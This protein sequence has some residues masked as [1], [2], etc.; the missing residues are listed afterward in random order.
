MNL[1]KLLLIVLAL[2][3]SNQVEFYDIHSNYEVKPNDSIKLELALK[4]VN[5]TPLYITVKFWTKD[6]T[7]KLLS[8]EF[9]NEMILSQATIYQELTASQL[10][11]NTFEFNIKNPTDKMQVF[12]GFGAI[13]D[14]PMPKLNIDFAF[15]F[16]KSEKGTSIN[17]NEFYTGS[18][19]DNLRYMAYYS[20]EK[21]DPLTPYEVLLD[22]DI[23]T[24]ETFEFQVG[25]YIPNRIYTNFFIALI[26]SQT[27][28][29]KMYVNFKPFS[30]CDILD[31]TKVLSSSIPTETLYCF[32]HSEKGESYLTAWS[33][34]E[35]YKLDIS[36]YYEIDGM[37]NSENLKYSL[38]NAK[39]IKLEVPSFKKTAYSVIMI[40]ATSSILNN[41]SYFHL[42]LIPKL[43]HFVAL[44][45][46]DEI[47]YHSSPF[48]KSVMLEINRDQTESINNVKIQVFSETDIIESVELFQGESQNQFT[49]LSLAK[50]INGAYILIQSLQPNNTASKL[51]ATIKL[52]ASASINLENLVRATLT[53]NEIIELEN[54]KELA[55]YDTQNFLRLSYLLEIGEQTSFVLNENFDYSTIKVFISDKQNNFRI[56]DFTGEEVK[57]NEGIVHFSSN[58]YP[59]A[60]SVLIEGLLAYPRKGYSLNISVVETFDD[61]FNYVLNVGSTSNDPAV[62][63]LKPNSAMTYFDKYYVYS[64]EKG[65]IV[66]FLVSFGEPIVRYKDADKSDIRIQLSESMSILSIPKEVRIRSKPIY[67]TIFI[68]DSVYAAIQIL[69]ST[70]EFSFEST[71]NNPIKFDLMNKTSEI[72]RFKLPNKVQKLYFFP[73]FDFGSAEIYAF[74]EDLSQS[75]DPTQ[76]LQ[77]NFK[78]AKILTKE[79]DTVIVKETDNFLCIRVMATEDTV[80]SIIV[81]DGD[82]TR[83]ITN[84]T[85]R[86]IFLSKETVLTYKSEANLKKDMYIVLQ[87][88]N[89]IFQFKFDSLDREVL[90]K[91][92][93]YVNQ[94][95]DL[96]KNIILNIEAGK[97][98]IVY[99]EFFEKDS[100]SITRQSSGIQKLKTKSGVSQLLFDIPASNQTSIHNFSLSLQKNFRFLKVSHLLLMTERYETKEDDTILKKF[101]Y[102]QLVDNSV[103]KNGMQSYNIAIQAKP[104][105]Y[106]LIVYFELDFADSVEIQTS[107]RISKENQLLLSKTPNKFNLDSNLALILNPSSFMIKMTEDQAALISIYSS[108]IEKENNCAYEV[109]NIYNMI[110]R[111]ALHLILESSSGVIITLH[112]LTQKT[113]F[114]VSA[115]IIPFNNSDTYPNL[116]LSD[117]QRELIV[118]ISQSNS[119]KSQEVT[120]TVSPKEK[121]SRKATFFGFVGPSKTTAENVSFQDFFENKSNFNELVGN[122]FKFEKVADEFSYYC[123]LVSKDND[124]GIVEI[125]N[126][127]YFDFKDFLDTQDSSNTTFAYILI[128]IAAFLIA[129][130]ITAV[131][132]YFACIRKKREDFVDTVIA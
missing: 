36:V 35:A 48:S 126:T 84:Q 127:K 79:F 88:I 39:S 38:T 125:Y 24:Y 108:S 45:P 121:A 89:E 18:S 40:N 46:G 13:I 128:G 109:N 64:P 53:L 30:A 94:N 115:S 19:S 5:Q 28:V 51:F 50:L 118:D 105:N 62:F 98:T 83:P 99:L 31:P 116:T 32:N 132:V 113:K 73:L 129:G 123:T 47:L 12:V 103:S 52:K 10:K 131:I 122:E 90:Q 15:S 102:Y 42:S 81:S 66:D 34:S 78:K 124:T 3:S 26:D 104:I 68:K 56:Q 114:Y 80:G 86:A 14:I 4:G 6:D 11:M 112:C 130:L 23:K 59:Q 75:E 82:S 97:S 27:G 55:W 8:N 106:S 70:K 120:V 49:S 22:E 87:S 65:K 91:S 119:S 85:P 7:L 41:I 21:A 37:L 33:N 71:L 9:T 72:I 1:L 25:E 95:L 93:S 117:I 44:E 43:S 63:S 60:R 76:S 17:S 69:G 96:S 2:S 58:N 29:I 110:D 101:M 67:V 77:P 16:N 61:E 100:N 74:L 107:Q 57:V 20:S 111:P 92:V 54:S